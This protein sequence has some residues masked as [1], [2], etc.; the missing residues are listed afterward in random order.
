ML[1]SG[2]SQTL[3]VD[4]AELLLESKSESV[5]VQSTSSS[6]IFGTLLIPETSELDAMS[7]R[8]VSPVAEPVPVVNLPQQQAVVGEPVLEAESDDEFDPILLPGPGSREQ[9]KIDCRF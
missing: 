1:N 8:A 3:T 2:Q 5:K 6:F 9:S 7:V 4:S